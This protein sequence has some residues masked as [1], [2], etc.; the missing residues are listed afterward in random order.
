MRHVI[1]DGLEIPMRDGCI[2]RADVWRPSGGAAHPVLLQRTPYRREDVH[3]AQYISALEFQAALR[4]GYAV[5]V[6][7]TRGRYGSDGDFVPF[8]NE[9]QDGADTI[10]WI[11][12]QA[13]C[14]G[15][16]GM[17]GASY[18]G[19]TQVLAATQNPDGLVAIAPQLTTARH[20]ETWTWR[21]GALQLGFVLLWIMEALGLPD[22]E[23][24]A[25]TLDPDVAD[26]LARVLDQLRADPHAAFAALPLAD[27]DLIELA[28]Y[29]ADWFD[30]DLAAGAASDPAHLAPLA[31]SRPAMLVTAGWN[32]LFLEGSLELFETARGRGHGRDQ[33]IIGPWSHGNPKDWQGDFW[34]GYAAS[35]ALLSEAQLDFFDA[36]MGDADM[37]AAPVRYFRTGSDT[38]H[39][40]PDWPLP[41]T[42]RLVLHMNGDDLSPAAPTGPFE[43]RFV[44]D[45]AHPV[46]TVG[47]ATFLP[48]LLVGTNS[49]AMEQAQIEARDDV[50]VFT[51]APIEA[52]LEVT[53]TVTLSLNAT[54]DAPTTDWAA[55]LCVV[56]PEGPSY[57]LVDGIQRV[58]CPARAPVEI[59]LGSISHLFPAGSRI[60]LQI[61]GSNFP[62][63][64]RNPQSGV[65]PAEARA[66]D[67]RIAQQVITGGR[68]SLPVIAEAYPE[69]PGLVQPRLIRLA[70][71]PP[72]SPDR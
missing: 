47:G 40:A 65:S 72:G 50:L 57:G 63:F 27:P 21:G 66:E 42:N 4:R 58:T 6:Q 29:L 60:R 67:V 70:G 30:S 12:E 52:P 9:A 7:D 5:V 45:P 13:F 62:R 43:R 56:L 14:D 71:D 18:V 69:K 8:A 26:R 51:S 59:T 55:R 16:V 15:R 17:F 19:A 38:W 2:L 49:G 39:A 61:A 31:A 3:G 10:A 23:R 32:D 53:G 22:L 41:D 25:G 64:D 34:H 36:V 35:T 28:P 33:L 37:P 46:P 54:T 68:L 1:E 44:S 11:R 48:G 20:G 24:R